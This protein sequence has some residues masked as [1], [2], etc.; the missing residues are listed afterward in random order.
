VQHVPGV[1]GYHQ[2]PRFSAHAIGH[3]EYNY[4]DLEAYA[5]GKLW[6][7]QPGVSI[8]DPHTRASLIFPSFPGTEG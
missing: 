7:L 2:G 3:H 5:Y 1:R 6:Q 4:W 8:S